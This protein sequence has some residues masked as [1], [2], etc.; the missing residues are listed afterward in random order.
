MF[1]FPLRCQQTLWKGEKEP[2]GPR[3]TWDHPSG[4]D[5]QCGPPQVVLG[6]SGALFKDCI[7]RGS[8]REGLH[9]QR[10]EGCPP[11]RLIPVCLG[12]GLSLLRPASALRPRTLHS[13]LSCRPLGPRGCAARKV[14]CGAPHTPGRRGSQKWEK[15]LPKVQGP[16]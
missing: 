3:G 6:G 11:K 2:L 12:W 5:S 4:Q 15:W 9:P 14:E 10:V 16:R 7:P 8:L 13:S 1:P